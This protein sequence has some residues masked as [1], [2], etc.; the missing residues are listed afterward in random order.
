[1]KGSK[2]R[3]PPKESYDHDEKRPRHDSAD[4]SSRTPDI[5]SSG[6]LGS[7]YV[8]GSSASTSYFEQQRRTSLTLPGVAELSLLP[9]QS[10]K[11]RSDANMNSPTKL[12]A[13]S[14]DYP[15]HGKQ[16]M[17]R[18]QNH[19]QYSHA[20]HYSPVSEN[21]TPIEGSTRPGHRW[22]VSLPPPVSAA[23]SP[24]SS[25]SSVLSTYSTGSSSHGMT[26]TSPPQLVSA[27]SPRASIAATAAGSNTASGPRFPNAHKKLSLRNP[28]TDGC[29][30]CE[31]GGS[32]PCVD[33]LVNMDEPE[34]DEDEDDDEVLY[35]EIK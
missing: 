32:C 8:T 29:G 20:S 11:S 31:E 21:T 7:P 30:N 9:G 33:T 23:M 2:R 15:N 16:P 24:S 14:G 18:S 34:A 3:S 1:L 6:S 28:A 25:T 26:A 12:P 27:P 17:H 5:S 22:G 10:S 4:R 13:I 19:G 35:T